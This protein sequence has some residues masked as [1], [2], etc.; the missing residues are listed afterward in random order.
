MTQ[1]RPSCGL[2]TL[3]GKIYA[4]GGSTL[5]ASIPVGNSIYLRPIVGTNECYDPKT[6]K[7]VT[8]KSMPT[9]RESFAIVACEGKIYCIGGVAFTPDQT[10]LYYSDAN[11]VYDP[12]TDS[13][14]SKA[15]FP[16]NDMPPHV[17]VVNGQIFAITHGGVLYM[18]DLVADSWN[19]KASVS[20]NYGSY[21]QIYVVNR[22]IFAITCGKM[23]GYDLTTDSWIT[24]ADM[25]F[26]GSGTFSAVVDNKIIFGVNISKELYGAYTFNVQLKVLIYDPKTDVWSEGKPSPEPTLYIDTSGMTG[27]TMGM[28]APKNI[29]VFGAAYDEIYAAGQPF[30]WAYDPVN[31][32]WSTAKSMPQF[33]PDESRFTCGV[34]IVDDVLY[35]IGATVNKQ[36]VPIGYGTLSPDTSTTV[37]LVPSD[38]SVP[39][40]SAS[41]W[42]F[43]TRPVVVVTVLT[44]GVV[45]V[46]SY[47]FLRKKRNKR[48]NKYD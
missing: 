7:W 21:P 6:D 2:V 41:L 37:D 31:N 36:Y 42:S 16:I 44:I 35:V 8:L 10:K 32:D 3:D 29:Y 4:I 47:F 20:S 1:T 11:E 15:F 33:T 24:K 30:T 13:W 14:S 25:P 28:Y 45:T 19:N 9:P 22:Q 18:Y 23:Y 26:S 46:S 39:S 17:F 38:Y 43:L 34:M 40:D 27:A 12:A 5:E 48:D